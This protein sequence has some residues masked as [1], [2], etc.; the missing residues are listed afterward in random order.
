V[1]CSAQ[2][3]HAASN[4]AHTNCPHL[5]RRVVGVRAKRPE[6]VLARRHR[7]GAADLVGRDDA[8]VDE[9]LGERLGHLL[10]LGGV[11]LPFFKGTV[12]GCGEQPAT[13]A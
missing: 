2:H 8:A 12:L 4:A 10:F 7:V 13:P 3:T 5:E 6:Q 11:L 1:K 9:A